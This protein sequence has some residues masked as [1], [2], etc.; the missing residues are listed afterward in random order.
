MADKKPSNNQ[1][2]TGEA[3]SKTATSSTTATSA[4]GA[5][6]FGRRLGLGAII[7]IS[8]AGL[9]VLVGTGFAGAAIA[10]AVDHGTRGHVQVGQGPEKMRDHAEGPMQGKGDGPREGKGDGSREGK[11][12]GHRDGEMK[13][14]QMPGGPMTPEGPAD[15]NNEVTPKG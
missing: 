13:H 9:A 12:D 8:A 3:K 14:G 11:G 4:N 5:S 7:G 6:L 2:A 1:P 10:N 15:T